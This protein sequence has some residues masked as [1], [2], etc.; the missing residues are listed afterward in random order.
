[1]S[2]DDI[3]DIEDT[4]GGGKQKFAQC[5]SCVHCYHYLCALVHM[6]RM[7]TNVITWSSSEVLWARKEKKAFELYISGRLWHRTCRSGRLWASLWSPLWALVDPPA[8]NRPPFSR[9]LPSWRPRAQH[10]THAYSSR[11]VPHFAEP[12]VLHLVVPLT[13]KHKEQRIIT[14]TSNNVSWWYHPTSRQQ[15]VVTAQSQHIM[16]IFIVIMPSLQ[17]MLSPACRSG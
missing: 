5:E 6:N 16:K 9:C 4:R 13:Y 15:S 8:K 12:A 10:R 14:K 7:S 3:I 11:P 2:C 17:G 1:M